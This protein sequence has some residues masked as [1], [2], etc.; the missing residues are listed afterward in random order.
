MINSDAK[1][2]KQ[3]QQMAMWTDLF[4]T[5]LIAFLMLDKLPQ[6]TQMQM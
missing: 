5:S 4:E 6:A 2:V 1:M 3:A